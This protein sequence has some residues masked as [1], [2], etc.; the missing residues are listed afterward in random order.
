MAEARIFIDHVRGSRR[1]TRQEFPAGTRVRFGRHPQNEVAFHARRDLDASSRHA[2]LVPEGEG[3]GDGGGTGHGYVLRDL[4]S[5]N[6]TLIDGQARSEIRIAPDT[7]IT[8]AFGASGPVVRI[9]IGAA[10]PEPPPGLLQR[11]WRRVRGP[12]RG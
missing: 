10:A 5:S 8:V 3:E 12:A 2:E 11:V 1:R 7:P 9:F 6:G 4:G